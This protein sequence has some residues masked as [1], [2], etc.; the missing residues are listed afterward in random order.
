MGKQERPWQ[1]SEELL[2][3]FG[4]KTDSARCKYREFVDKGIHM[5]RSDDLTGG[6]LI[7]S[8]GGWAA[9]KELQKSKVHVKSDERI[10][11]DG[12]YLAGFL[13]FKKEL[14]EEAEQ[15]LVTAYKNYRKLGTCFSKYGISATMSLPITDEVP[16][17]VG[18]NVRGILLALVEIYQRQEKWKNALDC[19]NKLRKLEPDDVV[20]K[21]SVAEILMEAHSDDRNVFRRVVRLAEGVENESEIHAAL[22]L[23][24][25]KALRKLHVNE[26]ARDVLTRA[27]RR[28]KGRS[29]ELLP[30]LRYERALVYE[31][32]GQHKRARSEFEKLYAEAADYEDLEERLSLI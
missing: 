31:D 18:P 4:K 11:G 32:L 7:R 9:V 6:G 16:A 13:A 8:A 12:T 14:L 15:H 5:G 23:Y 25:A 29:D 24:K 17:H 27:L 3:Y 2:R 21:L 30:A 1:S 22:L 10:L 28:K 20:V 26:A 19:L